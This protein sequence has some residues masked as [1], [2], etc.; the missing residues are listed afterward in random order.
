MA[1]IGILILLLMLHAGWWCLRGIGAVLVVAGLPL[2]AR[3]LWISGLSC[4][5]AVGLGLF[6][7]SIYF[8]EG[9]IFAIA[10]F[11]SIIHLV[12]LRMAQS[13]PTEIL[14]S[15]VA[16]LTLGLGAWINVAILLWIFIPKLPVFATV[17]LPWAVW[18]FVGF[19]LPDIRNR[20]EFLRCRLPLRTGTKVSIL[21]AYPKGT[22][23]RLPPPEDLEYLPRPRHTDYDSWVMSIVADLQGSRHMPRNDS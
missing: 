9:L 23:S 11:I 12:H 13:L 8:F 3:L 5:A 22:L 2:T 7:V 10:L 16:T 19:V 15:N 4:S 6:L 20:R 18:G 21:T 1:I 17:H 14:P